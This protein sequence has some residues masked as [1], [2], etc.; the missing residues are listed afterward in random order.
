MKLRS[1]KL[2]WAPITKRSY[3]ISLKRSTSSRFGREDIQKHGNLMGLLSSFNKKSRVIRHKLC[4]E[5]PVR[6]ATFYTS[7]IFYYVNVF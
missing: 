7:Y 2:R 5:I 3:Q 1:V 6:R 4:G